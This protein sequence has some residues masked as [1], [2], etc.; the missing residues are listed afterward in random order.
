MSISSL[1]MSPSSSFLADE[2]L[3]IVSAFIRGAKYG[4]KIR[5]PHA[6]VMTCLFRNDL[7]PREKVRLVL[8]LVYEHAS[9]LAI[10]ASIYKTS[11]AILKFSSR[12]LQDGRYEHRHQ[13]RVW[14]YFG[15]FVMTLI[16][17]GPSLSNTNE[18]CNDDL[19]T[20]AP[21]PANVGQPERPYHSF[22]AG[23]IGGYFVW[24]RYSSVNHQI[25]LYLT[26][27]ILVG[28]IKRGYEFMLTKSSHHPSSIF[29]QNTTYRIISATV[30]GTVM[31]LFEE[32]PHVLHKSLRQSMDEIYHS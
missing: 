1:T 19:S 22:L 9:N 5:L 23:A 15:R 25:V 26:S 2:L 29:Q 11:L 30:W 8:K 32:S 27:R 3:A 31:L 13:Q 6:A 20:A 24:G 7:L 28:S 16:V 4:L 21:I 17:D 14:K 18:G 12:C 10:F